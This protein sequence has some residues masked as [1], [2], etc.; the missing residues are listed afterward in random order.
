MM[1]RTSA[2][3]R[4]DAHLC[5]RGSLSHPNKCNKCVYLS[6]AG[7][8]QTSAEKTDDV[9]RSFI[10]IYDALT[11]GL[12]EDLTSAGQ[13]A[14]AHSP[15]ALRRHKASLWKQLEERRRGV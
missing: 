2:S 5:G 14:A 13:T 12:A 15:S 1:R 10:L 11:E 7:V 9:V 8:T 4:V 6:S 3:W